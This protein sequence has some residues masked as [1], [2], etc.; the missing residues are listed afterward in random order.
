[1]LANMNTATTRNITT[2]TNVQ[3]AQRLS[4]R[5]RSREGRRYKRERIKASLLAEWRYEP[6]KGQRPMPK[7]EPGKRRYDEGIVPGRNWQEALRVGK[8]K[9]LELLRLEPS[10]YHSS[11]HLSQYLQWAKEELQAQREKESKALQAQREKEAK[12]LRT[13][14]E[15]KAGAFEIGRLI[16]GFL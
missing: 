16:Q 7:A 5:S 2:T 4:S 9:T 12:A 11:V 10:G 6:T 3:T 13:Q 1:M 8:E 14:R 15:E